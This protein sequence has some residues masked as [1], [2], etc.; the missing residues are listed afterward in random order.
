[1]QYKHFSD[2]SLLLKQQQGEDRMSAAHTRISL[3]SKRELDST[4]K[5]EEDRREETVIPSAGGVFEDIAMSLV[6]REI[7]L[8]VLV[9][10]H[11]AFLKTNSSQAEP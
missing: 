2:L 8:E 1:R 5:V 6:N 9:R 10:S 11:T 3:L 4:N 7:I